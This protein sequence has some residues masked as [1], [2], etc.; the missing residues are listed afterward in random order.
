MKEINKDLLKECAH[1]L[2][3]DMN[4]EEYDTL[5]EEFKIVTSQ[6]E[7]IGKIEGL[8]NEEP[9]TFPFDCSIDY[10]REDEVNSTISKEDA[11]KNA[12]DTF[13]GQ[14]RLPKVVL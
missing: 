7:M 5:L 10:L 11:L 12:K 14:I 1:N 6:L 9:M 4:E 2:M 13:Q 3:F 8:D